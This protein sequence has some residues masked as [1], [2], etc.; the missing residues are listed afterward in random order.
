MVAFDGKSTM[1][2]DVAMA[3]SNPFLFSQAVLKPLTSSV[4]RFVRRK[5]V[6]KLESHGGLHKINAWVDSMRASSP[7]KSPPLSPDHDSWMLRAAVKV[8]AKYFPTKIVSGKGKDKVHDIAK[9]R[10]L[11]YAGSHGMDIEG[12]SN[13]ND[14]KSIV[15]QP[16]SEF[17]P[18][19][20]HVYNR[21]IE[22]TMF[23]E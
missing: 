4:G 23:I 18:I 5:P 19:I 9:L 13:G 2:V 12:P 11:Y 21:L 8:V 6:K 20:N 7:A 3:T 17:L 16:T 22:K 10:E 14:D 15:F 1:K